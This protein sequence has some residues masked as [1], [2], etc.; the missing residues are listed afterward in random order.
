[1]NF[2]PGATAIVRALYDQHLELARGSDEERRRLTLMM[3]Q[4]F[5]ARFGPR[6]GVKASSKTAPQS[7]DTIAFDNMDGTFDAFDWQNGTTREPQVSDGQTPTFAR[8]G[9]QWFIDV[10]PHDFLAPAAPVQQPG[11]SAPPKTDEQLERLIDI[12]NTAIASLEMMTRALQVVSD[13]L[14]EIKATGV[15]VH[16]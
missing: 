10:V 5:A 4:T 16:L 3:A 14:L 15:R 11:T 7:K 13:R 8:I 9:N 6:W 2:P 1:M 12:L